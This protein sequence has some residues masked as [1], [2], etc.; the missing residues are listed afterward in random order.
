MVPS[1]DPTQHLRIG[2][3]QMRCEKGAL[4]ANL[5][6]MARYLAQASACGVEILCLPEM[7]LSGYIDPTRQ[8]EAALRLD[9][10]E[11][12]QLL[13]MTRGRYTTVLAGTVEARP[14][15]KPFI[16]QIVA[17]DG[18]LVGFYR[19][20]TIEDEEVAWFS[21]G[22]AT[23]IFRQG[24]LTYGLAICADIGNEALYAAYARQGAQ[25]V[26]ELAAPGLYGEQATRDWRSGFLWWQG[27]CDTHLSRYAQTYGLWIAVATQAG[28]TV[29]E[30][31][32]GG[33][34]V[35]APDGRRLYATPDWSPGAVYLELD[36]QGRAVS[37]CVD[38]D[39]PA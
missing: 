8:P 5:A 14:E 31:F 17:R 4:A 16:T 22:E 18:R 23:P 36:L 34:Y 10:P 7:S 13:E 33:G 19:K 28:R 38:D 27:E 12:G 9:G 20:I 2:L 25:I 37:S 1:T 21:P 24:A 32:P 30:D 35:Y 11:V 15:G 39:A 6:D 3:V 29:D 26:F